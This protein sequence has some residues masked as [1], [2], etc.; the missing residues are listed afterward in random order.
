MRPN[1]KTT[2]LRMRRWDT[3]RRKLVASPRR[4]LTDSCGATAIMMAVA[5]PVMILGMG[6]GAETGFQYMTQRKLQ[7]AAD[8]SAH[9]GAARL[10]AGDDLTAITAAATHVAAQGGF[11]AVVGDIEVNTPPHS[12]LAANN[13]Q[14][15][16]VILNQP[17]QRYFSAL[18]SDEPVLIGARAVARVM[19]TGSS[20]CVLAL[21]PTA[22]GAITVSG[23][24][25]VALNGCDIASN[26]NAADALLMSGTSAQ[27]S[28]HC[29]HTVGQSVVTS[30][31]QLSGCPAVREFAPVV[32]DP[33]ADVVEP[34]AVGACHN[35]N[36]GSPNS[37]TTLTPNND[38]PSGVKSMRFCGGLTVK[39]DVVF[40]PG[41]YIVEGGDLSIHS[42]G[43]GSSAQ[44]SLTGSD[45]TLFM[46]GSARIVINGNA[47]LSLTAPSSGPFSGLLYFA[48]R[49]QTGITHRLSGTSGSI[50]QGAVYA[51]ASTLVMT[52]NSKSIGGCTQI[53]GRFVTFT[54]NSTLK[55]DCADSGTSDILAN[56]TI[57]IV[58]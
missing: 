37:T 54:G 9:A 43:E 57:S 6:L 46:T 5:L 7:H 31:L 38:H 49:S 2:F 10:R 58:E 13:P 47:A 29:A 26:S 11:N 27:L 33:Y 21:S 16:E 3:W 39:G 55:A 14:S 15:V 40:E 45:V 20:A 17:Q 44:P 18:I 56:Q 32:R 41:L 53:I 8:L 30:Q 25:T 51:P 28:A 22:S 1:R 52:G 34:A 36:V 19:D 42:A 12:G 50:V 48:S 4:F 23:S 35:G 24:T